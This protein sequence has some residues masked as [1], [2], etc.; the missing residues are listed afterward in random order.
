LRLGVAGWPQNI[1]DKWVTG[2]IFL[3]KEIGVGGL[4]VGLASFYHFFKYRGL[5]IT[6][7]SSLFVLE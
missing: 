5:A 2:K 3:I 4:P 6:V 1:A 7:A